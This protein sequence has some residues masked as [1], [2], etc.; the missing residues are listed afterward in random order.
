[1]A[2]I[3][4]RKVQSF[5]VRSTG[6][7]IRQPLPTRNNPNLKNKKG[8]VAANNKRNQLVIRKTIEV[9][10]PKIQ[11][12]YVLN[13]GC[14]TLVDNESLSSYHLKS[15]RDVCCRKNG[16]G[17]RWSSTKKI[18]SVFNSRAGTLP[19]GSFERTEDELIVSLPRSDHQDFFPRD[20]MAHDMKKKNNKQTKSKVKAKVR[21]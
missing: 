11:S 8:P 7:A 14:Q 18:Y 9:V 10:P 20:Y 17:T 12:P 5:F 16:L 4:P 3:V 6:L 1:M 2:T 19:R 21:S 13:P 15:K